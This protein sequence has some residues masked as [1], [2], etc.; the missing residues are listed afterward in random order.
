MIDLFI[1]V[2][3]VSTD[4]QIKG[5]SLRIQERD[6]RAYAERLGAK[7]VIIIPD[8]I[9]GTIPIRERP[10]GRRL[11]SYIDQ[12]PASCAVCFTDT[13][14]I[15]RDVD[16]FEVVQLMRDLRVAGIEFH[17]LNRGRIDLNDPFAKVLV[18]M[19][20]A[21]AGHDNQ[22]RA[23]KST[24][25]RRAK[26]AR[27][28]VGSGHPPYCHDRTGARR[29]LDYT[30][31]TRRAD[32]IRQ[33]AHMI[34]GGSSTEAAARWLEREGA[35]V[36]ATLHGGHA[37]GWYQ[38]TLL[39]VLRNRA[40]IGIFKHGPVE[41]RRDDLRIL[42]DETWDKLQAA[43]TEHKAWP[44]ASPR[45]YLL[46]GRLRCSCGRRMVGRYGTRGNTYYHC[47][48]IDNR[49]LVVL[50]IFGVQTQVHGQQRGERRVTITLGILE[51][52][53]LEIDKV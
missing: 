30:V 40:L 9:T 36:P 27:A 19:E 38:S 18:F 51:S 16:V 11:Y 47:T 20:G 28:I 32:L 5:D 43:L 49:R 31:N 24:A 6:M 12:R 41:T 25:G 45:N 14:R 48:S 29:A 1:G 7:R 10:G 13:S 52:V 50:A 15:A 42:D 3:R 23:Q 21:A 8:D 46:S 53:T 39:R 2:P 4:E 35:P 33:A 34:I 22:L 37:R 17:I 26:A 44:K